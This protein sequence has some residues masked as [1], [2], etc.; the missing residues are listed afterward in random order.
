[1]PTPACL[2]LLDEPHVR[3]GDV[4]HDLFPSRPAQLLIYLACRGSG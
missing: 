3:L 2:Y 4:R 1:M